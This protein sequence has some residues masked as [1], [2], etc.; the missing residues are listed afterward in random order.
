MIKKIVKLL[1]LT[2]SPLLMLAGQ[3]RAETLPPPVWRGDTVR[4]VIPRDFPPTYFEDA[5]TGRAAGFAVDITNE[6]A[7]RAGLKVEY[8]YG[9]AWQEIEQMLLDGR[10]MWLPTLPLMKNGRRCLPSHPQ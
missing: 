10:P 1:F 6:I 2:L 7:S 8:V 5:K 9:K 3:V 4:I